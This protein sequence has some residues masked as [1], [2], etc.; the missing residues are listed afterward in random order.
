MIADL[1]N[2]KHDY[3][4]KNDKLAYKEQDGISFD[5]VYGS[6]PRYYSENKWT[7]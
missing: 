4:V 1:K 2:Y 3:I 5:I 7:E 6:E